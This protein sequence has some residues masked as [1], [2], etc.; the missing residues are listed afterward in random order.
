MKGVVGM[1]SMEAPLVLPEP[2]MKNAGLYAGIGDYKKVEPKRYAPKTLRE[3]A[4]GRY[5]RA[6]KA[7]SFINAVSQVTSLHFADAYPYQLA[8]T[9]SA[10][11]TVYNSQSR[12][13]SRVFARFKDIAYSGVLRSDA[14]AM[15]VG[16]QA[17]LVQ[18]FDMNSRSILRKF[19]MH[20]RAVRAVKFSPQSYATIASAS[21]D[22]TVRI[23]DVA[24]GECVR[25]HDGHT[26]YARS[27]AGHPTASTTWASGS[28]DHTVRLWDNRDGSTSA[29][30][31]L[32]HGAPVEDIAWL[33]SGSLLVSVGGQDACV[34]DVLGGGKLLKRLRCHQKTIMSCHVAADGGPPPSFDN[35]VSVQ[36]GSVGRAT[37]PRLLTGSLDGHVKVHELDGFEVTH[38]AK[39]PG[40]VLSVALSPDAN[41]LA[42]GTANK[43]LSIR[44][45]TKPRVSH[46]ANGRGGGGGGDPGFHKVGP[47]GRRKAPRRLDAGSWQYFIRGQN[48]KAAE[49]DFKVQRMRSVRLQAHDR[50]LKRF[51]FTEALDASLA[52]GRPEVISAVIDEIS[53]HGA[54]GKALAGRDATA[55]QPVLR[56]VMKHIGNPRH[57]R[58]LVHVAGMVLDIYGG[59]VGAS[60][61][62]DAGL[63]LIRERVAVTL[64]L[65]DSLAALAGVASPLLTV[66]QLAAYSG[67]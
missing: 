67:R 56:Y 27:I 38:S 59:S 64:R 50:A 54:L 32:D 58:Q 47:S 55:L 4:E 26:D 13:Q 51:R 16:G 9:S 36:R 60:R 23:W 62:V 63:R 39:Y 40:P 53:A 10:R 24:A 46:D 11:V 61:E 6:Y 22:T 15:V 65:H 41:A 28:Y 21:D 66:G 37:A 33:P 7:P 30:M 1:T 17:G 44:R 25:R 45:R 57:T 2:K 20:T 12:K 14:R 18:L 35:F 49:G 5:W 42:V 34:W 3:T 48:A 52:G 29:S 31:T 8:V 19:E 43:L